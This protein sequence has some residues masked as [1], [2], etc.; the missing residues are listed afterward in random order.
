MHRDYVDGLGE[1]TEIKALTVEVEGTDI[2]S[3]LA[4]ELGLQYASYE[5]AVDYIQTSDIIIVA[6]NSTSPILRRKD[7][8]N[9]RQ[10]SMLRPVS[11]RF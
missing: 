4:E 8:E 6:T 7:L 11:H 1:F 5:Q 9:C 2:L 10:K 3:A